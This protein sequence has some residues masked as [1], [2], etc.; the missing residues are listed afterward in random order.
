MPAA[1]GLLIRNAAQI[2]TGR[3]SALRG[4]ALGEVQIHSDAW[5]YAE[6]G[7]IVAVGDRREVEPRVR[8]TPSELDAAGK[9]VIPGFIDSHTHAVFGGSRVD[10][11]VRKTAGATYAEIA[12]QGG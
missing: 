5:L 10:E 11:F 12:A 3:G 1:N 9:A 4:A 2:V 8:G 7:A 6:E